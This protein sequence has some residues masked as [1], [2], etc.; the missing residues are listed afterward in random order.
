MKGF[1][2]RDG[3]EYIAVALLY[4]GFLIVLVTLCTR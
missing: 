2:Y 1:R 3:A 4:I